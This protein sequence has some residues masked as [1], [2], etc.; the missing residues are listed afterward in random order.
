MNT[1][2]RF[3]SLPFEPFAD[4]F[5]MD[6]ASLRAA[7]AQRMRVQE[8]PGTP[9]R[10]SL[11]DAEVG[12][13]VVLVPFAHHEVASPYRAS[14]PI[15]VRRGAQ[16]ANPA[17]G[18]VPL[19]FRHRLLSLRGY[20]RAGMMVAAEVAAGTEL[21]TVLPAIFSDPAVAYI[22]VHNAKPGCFA[23]RVE[24]A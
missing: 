11:E 9:C 19:L 14:G 10:V 3:V 4:L 17:P 1:S 12:E 5:D 2:F 22:H 15:F 6:E 24:R 13:T 18:E 21:D 16:R 23:C 8:E 7:G 20:D